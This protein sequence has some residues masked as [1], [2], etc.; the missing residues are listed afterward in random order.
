MTEIEIP[1]RGGVRGRIERLAHEYMLKASALKIT[2]EIL[3]ED[4]R[5]QALQAAPKKFLQAMNHRNGTGTQ[6]TTKRGVVRKSESERLTEIVDYL[7]DHDGANTKEIAAAIGVQNPN[8]V[9]KLAPMV[10]RSTRMGRY[11]STWSL[12]KK[13]R[14]GATEWATVRADDGAPL[15]QIRRRKSAKQLPL[16]SGKRLTLFVLE[17]LAENKP[18][19]AVQLLNGLKL[20]G[21]ENNPKGMNGT[22]GSLMRSGWVKKKNGEG[23]VLTAKGNT[24]QGMLRKELE[25]SGRIGKDSYLAY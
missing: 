14:P 21:S 4:D 2:V 17:H 23:Y 25:G 20:N 12:K 13:P 19:T 5:K 3:D 1:S 10:A 24:H 11:P 22:M 9:T 8:T 16:I 6:V 15:A 7:T 18:S